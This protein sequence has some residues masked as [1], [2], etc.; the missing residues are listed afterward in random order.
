VVLAGAGLKAGQEDYWIRQIAES[1][2]EYLS[3][4]GETPCRWY[5][6]RAAAAG[7]SG[8]ALDEQCHALFEGKDPVTGAQ[9]AQPRWVADPRSKLPTGPLVERVAALTVERGSRSR[10]SRAVPPWPATSAR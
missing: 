10:H 7:L 5:G 2:C 3:G 9:L 8:I 1:R 4:Q 6:A